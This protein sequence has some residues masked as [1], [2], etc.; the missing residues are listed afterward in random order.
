MNCLFCNIAN[1]QLPASIVYEDDEI[2][3]FHDITPQAPTHIVII[4]RQHIATLNDLNA[5]TVALAGRLLL[6]VPLIA[7]EQ[8]VSETGYRTVINCNASGGQTVFHLHVHLLAGRLLTWP[9]G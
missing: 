2:I 8:G 7:K 1:K 3:A 6:R 9:P 4:P 5:Q